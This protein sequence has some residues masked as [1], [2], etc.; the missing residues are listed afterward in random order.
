MAAVTSQM[1][2]LGTSA[3][4]FSL[5][6]TEGGLVSFGE[7]DAPAY[8]VAF[9][10]NHCPYVIHIADELSAMGREYSAKGV[11]IYAISANDV[12]HSPADGVEKMAE[13]KAARGYVF[14]YLYDESQD[15][16]RAYRA[17]CTPDFYLFAADRKLVYRGQMDASR[18][19]NDLPVTGRDL[20]LALDAVLGGA[21]PTTDQL[22]SIGCSIKWKPGNEPAD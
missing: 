8:L 4:T 1:L 21:R 22:P 11:A 7:T 13:E 6:D 14:P 17:A 16:A 20:R 12:E 18:P 3:P 10:C 19:G 15:V 9:I 2:P 5:P